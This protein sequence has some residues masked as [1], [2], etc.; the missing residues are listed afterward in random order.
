MENLEVGSSLES[1]SSAGDGRQGGKIRKNVCLISYN[2][3]I[4]VGNSQTEL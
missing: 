1:N 4:M 2:V 3:N